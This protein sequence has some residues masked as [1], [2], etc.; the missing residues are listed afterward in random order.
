M[1]IN[2]CSHTAGSEMEYSLQPMCYERAW[3]KWLCDM[4]GDEYINIATPGAGNEHI[5]RTTQDWII[6]NVFLNK[7]YKKEDLHIVVMW[8]GFD[9]KEIYFPDTNEM[10]NINPMSDPKYHNTSLKYE[11]KQF[12]DVIV[13]FHDDLY[14]N[15]TNLRL[16]NNLCSFLEKYEIKYTFLNAL[17]SFIDLEKL[18]NDYR[19]HILYN[20]YYNNLWLYDDYKKEKHLGFFNFNYGFFEHLDKHPNFKWS[21]YSE[22]GHFGED[23]HKYWAK[24]V[25]NLINGKIKEKI[26]GKSLM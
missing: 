9:R 23:A 25:Y 8:S 24:I 16:V 12:Q 2:G 13:Y 15:L 21:I 22:K 3:G 17:H 26:N 20:S 1:L 18:N 14:S 11:L 10:D 4:T 19:N 5:C 7:L 6:Q